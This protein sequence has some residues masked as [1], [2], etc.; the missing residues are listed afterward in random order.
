MLLFF[1]LAESILWSGEKLIVSADPAGPSG[2]FGRQK[3]KAK[4]PF[5]VEE[6]GGMS[7]VG[8]QGGIQGGY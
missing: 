6:G 2:F 7:G 5:K 3:S 8:C 1:L 4:E